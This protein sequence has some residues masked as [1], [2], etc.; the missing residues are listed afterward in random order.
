MWLLAHSESL[1]ASLKWIKLFP[2]WTEFQEKVQEYLQAH[3]ES[4]IL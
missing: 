2:N 4:A 3:K 1:E